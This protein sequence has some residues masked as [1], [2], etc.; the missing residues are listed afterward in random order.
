MELDNFII[1]NINDYILITNK[2]KKNIEND[3][4]L[5][6]KTDLYYVNIESILDASIEFDIYCIL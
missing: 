1:E 5:I 3:W 6:S 2:E 4:I